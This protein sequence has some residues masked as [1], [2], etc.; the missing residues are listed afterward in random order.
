MSDREPL[1]IF[2]DGE[3]AMCSGFAAWAM[4]HDRDRRLSLEPAQSPAARHRL[5][6]AHARALEELHVWCAGDGVASGVDAVA[7]VLA[8][9]PGWRAATALITAPVLR[10]LSRAAYRWMASHR[11]W[12]GTPSCPLPGSANDRRNDLK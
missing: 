10:P 6:S 4:R 3:C 8:R 7:A 9:L 2:F 12:L 11:R 1:V 5:G